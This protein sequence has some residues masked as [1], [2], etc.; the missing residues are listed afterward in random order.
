MITITHDG[1]VRVASGY[2][3][4]TLTTDGTWRILATYSVQ[5]RVCVEPSHYDYQ[6]NATVPS[7]HEVLQVQHF[8]LGKSKE[9]ALEEISKRCADLQA[10]NNGLADEF[11]MEATKRQ[12]AEA[13]AEQ[14]EEKLARQKA[15][16]EKVRGLLDTRQEAFHR[17]EGAL[18][19]ARKALKI[20]R[21]EIGEARARELLGE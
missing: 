17:G 2:D 15:D 20:L 10:V 5:E 8:L 3:L 16:T 13:H 4:E 1:P 11:A 9:N 12:A 21:A 14:L 18:A 19:D 6:T 7:R